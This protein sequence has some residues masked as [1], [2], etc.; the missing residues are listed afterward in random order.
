[1]KY[2]IKFWKYLDGNKTIIC[3]TSASILQMAVQ[4]DIL[5]DSNGLKFI[6]NVLMLLGGGSLIHHAKKGYFKQN[7]GQ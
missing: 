7:K 2:L 6:I 5:N 1:M 4:N 3:M